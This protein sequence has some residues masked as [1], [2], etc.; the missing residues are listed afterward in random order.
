ML[1]YTILIM[2]SMTSK[3]NTGTV[4]QNNHPSCHEYLHCD[5]TDCPMF[6]DQSGDPCWKQHNSEYTHPFI[7]VL[8]EK[9]ITESV[10]KKCELCSYRMTFDHDEY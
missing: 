8:I 3:L 9:G 5:Q 6:K 1:E 2:I 4:S 7:L 10:E